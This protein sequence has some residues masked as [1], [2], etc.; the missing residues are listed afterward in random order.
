MEN[1]NSISDKITI[2]IVLPVYNGSLYM[3]KAIDSIIAQTYTNW[4]LIIVNDCSTDDSLKIALDYE[5]KDTR[6]KVISNKENIKLPRSL[7]AGFERA[8]GKYYTWTSDDNIYKENA[9][10]IMVNELESDDSCVMVY[11]DFTKI[12]SEGKIIERCFLPEGEEILFGSICGACFLYRKDA[13]KEV[14]G[15]DANLFLAEDYDYWIRLSQVGLLKHIHKDLYYYR[16][17]SGSLS[18]SRKNSVYNQTYKVLE[19]NF[20]YLYTASKERGME[21]RLFDVILSWTSDE[22]LS[23]VKNKLLIVNP[24]YIRYKR[25]NKIKGYIYNTKVGHLYSKMKGKLL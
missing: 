24:S 23:S 19:K 6:I 20:L 18:E 4:E 17:H 9:L 22:R 16:C 2:S 15:Y 25:I 10:E 21:F 14:G 3:S 12:D 5:K 8:I 7:N 1:S 11:S 13:A